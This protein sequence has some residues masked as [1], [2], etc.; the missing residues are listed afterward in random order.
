MTGEKRLAINRDFVCGL[1]AL[2]LAGGYYAVAADIQSSQLADDVGADGLP[3]TYAVALAALGSI[4]VLSNLPRGAVAETAGDTPTRNARD[5]FQ[6]KRALGMLA[7]GALY[8]LVA[9][10]LGYIVAIALVIV[11]TAM[12]QG[13]KLDWKLGLTAIAGAGLLWFVFVFLLH[14]HQPSGALFGPLFSG[15]R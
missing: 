5:L 12:Y 11:A 14:I 4:L 10:W 9:P 1:F 15:G 6:L 3:K 8:V 13:G 2:A 7:I